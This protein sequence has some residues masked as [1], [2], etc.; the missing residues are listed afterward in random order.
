MYSV[1]LVYNTKCYASDKASLVGC[2]AYLI[3]C[4]A[5]P[6][7]QFLRQKAFQ[8]D[9]EYKNHLDSDKEHQNNLIVPVGVV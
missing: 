9:R 7:G 1:T 2:K 3:G 5:C 6:V 4:K 8:S